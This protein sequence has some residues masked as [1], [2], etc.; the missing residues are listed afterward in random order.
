MSH[1]LL[2]LYKLFLHKHTLCNKLNAR[3]TINFISSAC[4]SH[5]PYIVTSLML[6]NQVPH[7]LNNY[8]L[9]IHLTNIVISATYSKLIFLVNGS[10]VNFDNIIPKNG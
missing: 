10:L 9:T 2:F 6:P 4:I 7:G 1:Y 8:T 5:K 3:D